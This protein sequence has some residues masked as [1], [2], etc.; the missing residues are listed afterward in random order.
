MDLAEL[1]S[2]LD[3]RRAGDAPVRIR[4][5][6]ITDDSRTVMPGSLFIARRGHSEDGR[7][8]A[9]QAA[10]AGA[11]AILTD[12]PTLAVGCH[13]PVAVVATGDV[14]GVG[15]RVAE[16]FYGRPSSK[17]RLAGVTGTNGKTTTTYLIHSMLNGAGVRC[18]LIGTVVVDDGVSVSPASLTTPPAVEISRTLG[19]MVDAGCGAC[20][21]E[22]SS[23]AL[24]QGRVA[25]LR[26][27]CAVFT[28][29]TG[30]HLDYHGTLEEYASA[31]ARLFE[32][33]EPGALA[34]VNADDPWSERMVERC[35]ARVLRCTAERGAADGRCAARTVE[36][37]MAGTRAVFTGPWGEFDARMGLVG[38]HNAMNALQALAVCHEFGVPA[39][40]LGERLA[41]ASAPPG[42]LEPVAPPG[43]PFA[44]YVDYA[45]TDDA[46]AKALAAVRPLVGPGGRLWAV[47]GCG[48]DRDRSKR[49]R[50]GDVASRLAD[51][52]VITSDN[53][54]R[55]RPGAIIGEIREGIDAGLL[56]KVT[57]LPEREEAIAHAITSA[58]A[59]DIVLIAG[60]GHEDYQI[61]PDGAGGTVTR[62]FDDRE[63]ARAALCGT[64]H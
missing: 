12:D 42:R 53:P 11:V 22:A 36:R 52:V 7:K 10:R 20:A 37:S 15:A 17:L 38:A 63:A 34:V 56:A 48:G 57:V 31:K 62:H 6:D 45:H 32:M 41:G 30:D 18:G 4:I 1:I 14:A 25:G 39:E 16:R 26:F 19:V 21:L 33:L 50:M 9:A 46:L 13:A 47:F 5:C 27:A 3:A 61:L 29:L 35:R 24:D 54:R 40:A 43:H 2:G 49:P 58:R 59:G 60:K 8:Y 28:N 51:R 55:E 44:V 64:A 23:H